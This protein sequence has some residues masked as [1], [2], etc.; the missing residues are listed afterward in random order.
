MLNPQGMVSECT[1]ENVFVARHG[2]FLTPPLAAGAL[3]GITQDSVMTIARDLGFECVL[4]ELTRSDVYVA[5]EMFLCGTAA[6]VSAVNSLDDRPIPCPGP[7]TTAIA[8]EY[9]KAVRGETDRY[10][11]WVEH[12]S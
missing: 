2:K 5:E 3:E 11:E 6:E 8:E 9:H 12:V 7:M 1:G 4:S 10:K